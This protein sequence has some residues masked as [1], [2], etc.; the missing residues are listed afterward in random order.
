[1]YQSTQ[2]RLA[3]EGKRKG[4]KKEEEIRDSSRNKKV[5]SDKYF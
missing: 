3:V 2:K 4:K 1:M 5:Q